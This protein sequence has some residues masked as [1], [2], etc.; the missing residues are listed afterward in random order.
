VAR[1]S[2]LEIHI[3]TCQDHITVK[4]ELRPKITKEKGEGLGLSNIQRRY[5][6]LTKK[7]I[8]YG[9]SDNHFVVSLPLL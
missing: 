5:S 2:P 9:I 4:N 3:E 7:H 1:F 6:L 8:H